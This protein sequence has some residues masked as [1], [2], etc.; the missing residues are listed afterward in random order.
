[1]KNKIFIHPEVYDQL[2]EILNFLSKVSVD[3]ATILVK[4]FHGVLE[5]IKEYPLLFPEYD[6]AA[7]KSL[8]YRK[9]VVNR[10]YV[11]IYS[12]RKDGI[13]VEL[14]LDCR[15]NN[16]WLLSDKFALNE[17]IVRQLKNSY[18]VNVTRVQ[19]R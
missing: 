16:K 19:I 11:I 8:N 13:H 17:K 1:M 6:D 5:Q 4:D 9:A 7:I 2:Y 14:M 18:Q 10:Y 3:A 12:V 15:K